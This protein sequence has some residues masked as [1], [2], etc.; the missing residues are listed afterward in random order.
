MASEYG[1]PQSHWSKFDDKETQLYCFFEGASA[2]SGNLVIRLYHEGRLAAET[3]GLHLELL[4][5][6][7]AV[8]ANRDRD[9]KFDGSDRTTEE[10]P[11]YFWLNNDHDEGNDD[12]AEDIEPITADSADF[13][14]S[15]KRD[16]EDFSRIHLE[17]SSIED[18]LVAGDLQFGLKW[19]NTTGDPEIKLYLHHD[20]LG[21]TDYLTDDVAS[22]MQINVSNYS[23]TLRD[24]SDARFL[25]TG[26]TFIFKRSFF[27][28]LSSS[29]IKPLLFEATGAGSG[30]LVPV[31]LKDGVEIGT[32][33]GVWF[34]LKNI[35]KMYQ[36]FT[37][38][39][40]TSADPAI[41]ASE[42]NDVSKSDLDEM[43]LSDDYI[44]F[45]HGWRMKT[46][47]RRYLAETAFKRLYWQGYKGRFG[48]FS[49][50]TEWT[51]RPLGTAITDTQNYMRSDQKAML[52]GQ[53]LSVTM[54]SLMFQYNDALKVFA[55]SMGNVVVSEALKQGGEAN[56]YV[57]CQS[58][59]VARAYDS[60]GP[61]RLTSQR[62]NDA[63]S[64]KVGF[65]ADFLDAVD[66]H[67][68]VFANYPPT[69]QVY[70]DGILGNLAS[71]QIINHHNRQDD[72]LAWWL[73]GQAKKPNGDYYYE[74][75]EDRWYLDDAIWPVP[76][77]ALFF[78]ADTYE[79][80]ARAA[81]PDSVPL[82]ASVTIGHSTAG[83]IT[84]NV[85]LNALY[86]FQ[87]GDEDHSAQF[88][89]TVQ[90]RWDY[91]ERLYNDFYP[92]P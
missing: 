22:G 41:I 3:R 85:N 35:K 52:S 4:K 72:A 78:P 11:Y 56:T 38:G 87:D 60:T 76:D 33:S 32:G 17:V 25:G 44:L 50:P 37:V 59:S 89:S 61:E 31:I 39:D 79:I 30:Q 28:G 90:R 62:I 16:L 55:H 45:V 47:E 80:F 19:E 14:I 54:N 63:L 1:V 21:G 13:V 12:T 43:S 83:E 73:A 53:G 23:N 66:D 18:A 8:D 6:N 68:D 65:I 67:P 71:E 82:G 58:A 84:G 46:W 51:S 74:S 27:T 75:R 36:H 34:D 9:I 42:I 7:V 5:V 2:G 70:Y 49:W 26:N 69:S 57:A 40:S 48:F 20:V 64:G 24:E 77:T 29:A 10:K 92:A 88:R 15:N 86:D 81:E 91:W